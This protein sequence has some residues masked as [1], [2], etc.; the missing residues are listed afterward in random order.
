VIVR[1]ISQIQFKSNDNFTDR[2]CDES[3][4]HMLKIVKS[5][6]HYS[7]PAMRW[8][9]QKTIYAIERIEDIIYD[10]LKLRGDKDN[11][12]LG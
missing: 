3:E 12:V 2:L 6:D 8:K 9:L 4:E 7:P 5:M 1:F 11:S 10:E